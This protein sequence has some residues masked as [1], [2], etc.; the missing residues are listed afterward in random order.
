M[1]LEEAADEEELL[2]EDEDE[3]VLSYVPDRVRLDPDALDSVPLRLFLLRRRFLSFLS[4]LRLNFLLLAVSLLRRP[5]KDPSEG[6]A[7]LPNPLG[8]SPVSPAMRGLGPGESTLDEAASLAAFSF[9]ARRFFSLFS[10][11]LR[12]FFLFFLRRRLES[13]EELLLLELEVPLDEVDEDENDEEED[14]LD[15]DF[16]WVAS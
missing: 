12:L 10:R 5:K 4:F 15:E 8:K 1:T 7:C 11:F 13:D 14:E 6:P 2:E 3:E 16:S 9:L